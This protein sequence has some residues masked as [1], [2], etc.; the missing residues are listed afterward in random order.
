MLDSTLNLNL[1]AAYA[2]FEQSM[3]WRLGSYAKTVIYRSAK[4]HVC[5]TCGGPKRDSTSLC[6]SC[7]SLRQQAEAL[8]VAHLMAD[9]VRI[10]NYAIK[11]DQMY[12]VM[13]GYKR[14]RPESKEDYCETLKYVLGDALV[15]H[16]SCLTHTSDGVMPSAWATIPSTTTSERYGQPHP[17]NGLV[18]PMLNKTI[19]EVKLLANEQKHRAIA[20]S[21]FSLDGSYSDETLRHVLLID[22]TWTSG[23]TAESASIMLKQSGA[24][25]VTIYCLA[26]IIDL[27]YCSRMIG[28]SVSDGYKQLTY[29]N[30]CPW[31]YDQC[32]MRNK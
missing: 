25:R 11:F 14:N 17:L 1:L 26:R 16:W 20:T 21:T 9:R 7:T 24:Q 10:A 6:Y 22:D 2:R 13:D 31:D 8:G 19:P 18:S 12:R 23:G 15:V 4:H 5:P 32:P 29:R 3:G 30:G 27:D 28:Q